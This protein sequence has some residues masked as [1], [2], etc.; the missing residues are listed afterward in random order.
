ML[1]LIKIISVIFGAALLIASF[2]LQTY[3]TCC[4]V[5]GKSKPLMWHFFGNL[6]EII[7]VFGAVY[8]VLCL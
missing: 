6:L 8:V 7:G 4:E 5:A 1:Y 3:A 2:V